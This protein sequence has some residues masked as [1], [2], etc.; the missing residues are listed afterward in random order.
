MSENENRNY[1]TSQLNINNNNV[2]VKSPKKIIKMIDEKQKDHK[3]DFRLYEIIQTLWCRRCLNKKLHK[4]YKLFKLGNEILN[5]Y[6]DISYIS[7]K[8]EEFEKIKFILFNEDQLA[9]FHFISNTVLSLNNMTDFSSKMNKY[10]AL[11]KNKE[12]LVK[13]VSEYKEKLKSNMLIS[14]VDGKLVELL[15][16]EVKKIIDL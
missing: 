4:K 14:E 9:L 15:D 1:Q 8:L 11:I 12:T 16:K 13:L 5:D 10:K 3:L 2:N 6:L 7:H